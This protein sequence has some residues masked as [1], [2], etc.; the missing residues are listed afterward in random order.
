MRTTGEIKE[1]DWADSSPGRW[2]AGFIYAPPLRESEVAVLEPFGPNWSITVN[3]PCQVWNHGNRNYETFAWSGGCV[4]GKAS[5]TGQLTYR[6]GAGV[7]QCGMRAGK[8]DGSG[9]LAW[10]DGFRYEGEWRNGRSR[11]QGIYARADGTGYEGSWREGCLGGR[12]GRR[13]WMGTSASAGG[14]D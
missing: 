11:G 8:M 9:V 1:Q 12:D 14:F 4:D 5:G 10:A 13:A 7:H 6:G 2:R 3:Q